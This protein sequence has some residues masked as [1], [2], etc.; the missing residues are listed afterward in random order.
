MGYL[1]DNH[2]DTPASVTVTNLDTGDVVALCATDVHPW[3]SAMADA[4][5]PAPEAVTEAP[6][7]LT[8]DP[9]HDDAA[10]DGA[11][12]PGLPD[13]AESPQPEPEPQAEPE[14]QDGDDLP[15]LSDLLEQARPELAQ[16]D[17]Q[18]ATPA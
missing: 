9:T 14:P 11:S 3:F 16:E 1:C 17:E 2:P 10:G 13:P 7:P 5:R 8:G 6:D 12:S 18:A 4:T 15:E